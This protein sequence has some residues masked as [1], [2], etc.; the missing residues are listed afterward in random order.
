MTEGIQDKTENRR[1][2]AGLDGQ[3]GVALDDLGGIP[4][5]DSRLPRPAIAQHP[6]GAGPSPGEGGAPG[7]RVDTRGTPKNT[8]PPPPLP[9]YDELATAYV[10][11]LARTYRWDQVQGYTGAPIAECARML[12]MAVVLRRAGFG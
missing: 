4:K 7:Q 5:Q 1:G 3:G 11:L 12:D 2:F 8:A 9:P 6:G 10:R